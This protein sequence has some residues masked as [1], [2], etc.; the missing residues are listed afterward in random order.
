MIRIF[1]VPLSGRERELLLGFGIE[2]LDLAR[3]LRL[4]PVLGRWVTVRLTEAELKALMWLACQAGGNGVGSPEGE[5]VLPALHRMSRVLN[6]EPALPDPEPAQPRPAL[7]LWRPGGP[8]LVLKEV[9]LRFSSRDRRCLERHRELLEDLPLDARDAL[10]AEGSGRVSL[11]FGEVLLLRDRLDET[12][13]AGGIPEIAAYGLAGVLRRI[14][15][16]LEEQW[17]PEQRGAWS[18]RRVRVSPDQRIPVALR[19]SEA[20][21]S[22]TLALPPAMA[23]A[24]EVDERGLS[25]RINL[26]LEQVEQLLGDILVRLEEERVARLEQRLDYVQ[27][28]FTDGREY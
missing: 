4:P 20:E 16:E 5:E 23:L 15:L 27:R 26:T 7:S 25:S 28:C 21:L 9:A 24:L 10:T 14:E 3:R 8:G 11:L 13:M 19:R 1:R 22:R 2:D 17:A 12:V 18:V 6:G